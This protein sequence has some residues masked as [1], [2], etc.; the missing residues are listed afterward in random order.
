MNYTNDMNR[1]LKK[2]VFVFGYIIFSIN[3]F[4]QIPPGYYEKIDGKTDRNLK[5]AL[6]II[7]KEHTVLNYNDLW[8]YFRTTDVRDDG[9]TV[10]DMYSNNIRY[11]SA[12]PGQSTAGMQKEHSLP[13]SW[14]AVSSDVDKYNAYTDLT[15]LLPSDGDANQ[16][17]SNDILG[18][19]ASSAIFNNGVTKVGQNTYVY[20]GSPKQEAFEPDDQYKGDFARTYFY[21]I[22]CYE[23]YA[24]Q[25]RSEALSMFNRETYPVLQPWAKDMLL[26]WSREDPVSEKEKKRNEN[27]FLYQGNRN[28]FIDFPNL[29]E[30]IWGDS[31]GYAFNLPEEYKAHEAI[32]MTP[33]N[34][35]D[36]YF[37]EIQPGEISEKTI[38]VK[39]QYLSG[40]LTAMLF[41][42]ATGNEY[43]RVSATSIPSALVNSDEGYEFT[44]TYTP[45]SYGT[46]SNSLVLLGG[47]FVGSTV[48]YL[49]GACSNETSIVPAGADF[50]DI[51]SQNREIFYRSYAPS[52][53]VYVYDILGNLIYTNV[54][55]GTWQSYSCPNAGIYIVKINDRTTKIIVK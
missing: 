2:L 34:L 36:M 5:T 29:A 27:V 38:I 45:L 19:V 51:Y 39:G 18:E 9:R 17:K 12:Y 37:G 42:S 41:G 10:W 25:W 21:M 6:S 1:K 7:L 55:T 52:G 44:L 13:K 26:K 43:F 20:S 54:C 4:S 8:Y 47:G 22:T 32:I 40:N 48:I 24:Q 16:A 11:F 3:T 23:D 50:P 53:K 14:W 49:N 35:S 15:H 28:P 31:V 30:Y 46:H 33:A